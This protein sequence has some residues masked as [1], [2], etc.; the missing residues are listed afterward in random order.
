M[1]LAQVRMNGTTEAAT[2]VINRCVVMCVD[3]PLY[4]FVEEKPGLQ[5]NAICRAMNRHLT[6]DDLPLP[7]WCPLPDAEGFDKAYTGELEVTTTDVVRKMEQIRL[8]AESVQDY[9]AASYPEEQGM[10]RADDALLFGLVESLGGLVGEAFAML[11][12]T[13]A[14][15]IWDI[16]ATEKP[17][18][19]AKDRIFRTGEECEEDK[20]LNEESKTHLCPRC[21][22]QL[23]A[24]GFC[25]KCNQKFVI[26]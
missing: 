6:R 22:N 26:M 2:L 21:S 5:P 16:M 14:T 4:H 8:M 19:V 17:L 13:D 23:A 11:N 15:V 18:D 24:N 9:S 12:I 25:E 1:K 10:I 3:C 20:P 7:G